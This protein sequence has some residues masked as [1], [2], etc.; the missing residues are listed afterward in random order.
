MFNRIKIVTS[1]MLVL[2]IFG[3]LLVLTGGLFYQ[4]VKNDKYNFQLTQS[5]KE[6]QSE[7][8]AAWN[9]LSQ[10]RTALSRA[11][12][13]QTLDQK[14]TSV[15]ETADE[16]LVQAAASYSLA[17][18]HYAVWQ[19]LLAAADL[20]DNYLID[21]KKKFNHYHG[22][23]AELFGLLR[24]GDII[25]FVANPA[26]L[27]QD[28]FQAALEAW[29]NDHQIQIEA[30]VQQ[31]LSSYHQSIWIVVNI[32]LLTLAVITA[33]WI[34]IRRILLHPLQEIMKQIG[35]ISTGDLTR[36]IPVQGNNEMAKLAGSLHQMQQALIGTISNV[37][38]GSD[39]ICTGVNEI[40]AGNND[41]SVRTEEQA[42]SLEETAASMEQL[43]AT[44]KQNAE[45]ARQA[46]QLANSA[47]EIA[48]KGGHVVDGVVQT[49]N[50]IASSSK[51]I[52]DIT[53]VIDGIAFQTNILALNA[54][55]EAAR[56]GE[57]GRGFAVVAGEVRS[58]A[59]RS[60]QAAKEIKGLIEDSVSRV[61]SG[62]L[63][64]GNAGDTM[65]EIVQAVTRVTDIM[66]EI[67]SASDEQSRGIS[68][69]GTAVSEMD[70]VTQQNASL[71][72][73]ST[74]AAAS[75]E[76]QA[77]RLNQAVA[78]FQLAQQLATQEVKREAK[79]PIVIKA[80]ELAAKSQGENWEAF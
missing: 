9:A 44:V 39:A 22:V 36:T 72:E 21:L 4:A 13:R 53:S 55:V 6:Q 79:A 80:P 24:A 12:L 76:E 61:D 57:Q 10:T 77:H 23:L 46:S 1:L 27:S 35:Y 18:K 7:I 41:L 34:L 63:Q 42:A 11:A 71:V 50:E 32:L 33:F 15:S 40:A 68:Q 69:V 17:E 75:L 52:A 74:S 20:K 28:N 26:Q 43:T 66:S 8:N 16:L 67:A 70:R 2:V 78:V 56:A 3:S 49:M 5:L 14:N 48:Q 37:R 54:A 45:N 31:N 19:T 29:T 62:T 64:V 25:G 59:Q 58:L 51:K 47:S 30:A 38:E 73:E 65:G 60:A